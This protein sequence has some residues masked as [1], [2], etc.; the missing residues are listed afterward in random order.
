M[1]T[2]LR[3]L[4]A[5][6]RG[7]LLAGVAAVVAV[8]LVLA[9]PG[10]DLDV[11]NVFRSG[12]AI[13]RHA[14]YVPSRPPGAP[15][16]EAIVGVAD[17]LGGPLLATAL[18]VVAAAV[19]IVVLHRLVAPD[20]PGPGGRWA[21]ALVAVNPWFAIA[22]TSAAD[23]VFALAFGLG[24]ALALRRDRWAVAGLLAAAGMGCRVG[25]ATLLVAAA[26]ATLTAGREH[27][28]PVAKAA[29]LAA[30]ATALAYL[31]SVL[32]AGGLDFARND[33]ATSSVVVQVGRFL[34]KDLLLVGLP[35]AVLLAIGLPA[36]LAILR[37]WST[38]WS[39]R[40]GIVGL[41]ASQLLFLRFPWKMA[42]LLP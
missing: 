20:A 9:G 29:G 18:S 6:A 3:T 35:T 26:V 4:D 10:N 16:H 25:T 32:D 37:D 23:Y 27:R 38:S 7:W 22:A 41:V 33:F 30:V 17:L 2:R 24:A 21:V 19:A 8:P 12:R 5:S 15:V 42:H 39:V 34:A 13:A 40:F 36:V 14:D 11:A 28:A 31:P 1:L